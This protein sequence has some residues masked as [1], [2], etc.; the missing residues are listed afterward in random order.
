MPDMEKTLFVLLSNLRMAHN[1]GLQ[2]M[3]AIVRSTELHRY[4]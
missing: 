3:L 4:A 1:H 2:W